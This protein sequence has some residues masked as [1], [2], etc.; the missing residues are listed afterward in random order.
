MGDG[1]GD[2]GEDEGRSAR[3]LFRHQPGQQVLPQRERDPEDKAK[4]R[5]RPRT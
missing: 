5:Q 3:L 4:P 2:D 1:D